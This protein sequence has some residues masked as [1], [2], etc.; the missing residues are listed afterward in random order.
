MYIGFQNMYSFALNKSV[1]NKLLS[2][3]IVMNLLGEMHSLYAKQCKIPCSISE[4]GKFS[5]SF[6][7]I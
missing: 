1:I 7:E 5:S 3:D 2:K 6:I 4:C